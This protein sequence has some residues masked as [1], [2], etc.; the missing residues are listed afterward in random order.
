MN[1]G[2]VM[3]DIAY[4]A[5]MNISV[6]EVAKKMRDLNVG[7]VPV[8]NEQNQLVGVVTVR[9]IVLK[10]IA[11]EADSMINVGNIMSEGVVSVTPSTDVH[12][13]ARKMKENKLGDCRLLKAIWL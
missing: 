6:G 12:E 11:K 8:C 1:V 4:V 3:T 5:P 7:S 13:A 10:G 2:N 9:D